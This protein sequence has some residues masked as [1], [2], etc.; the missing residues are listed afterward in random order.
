VFFQGN[1]FLHSLCFA[2]HRFKCLVCFTAVSSRG[3]QQGKGPF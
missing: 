2:H 3:C 1:S